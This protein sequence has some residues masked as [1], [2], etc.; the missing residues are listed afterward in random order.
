MKYYSMGQYENA[1]SE[2][3]KV[4]EIDPKDVNSKNNIEKAK[5]MLNK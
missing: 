2:W 4:L 5:T 1:I 3:E